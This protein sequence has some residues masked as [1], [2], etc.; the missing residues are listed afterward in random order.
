MTALIS[1]DGE[2]W[3]VDGT[4][5]TFR[6]VI[7]RLVSGEPPLLRFRM[8]T[9]GDEGFLLQ[10]SCFFEGD[11]TPYVVQRRDGDPDALARDIIEMYETWHAKRDD[12]AGLTLSQKLDKWKS[13]ISDI[14]GLPWPPPVRFIPL[15]NLM[16]D[17]PEWGQ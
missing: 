7:E 14:D 12:E 5:I 11:R 8:R 13:A 15:P 6:S 9:G 4:P 1:T 3:D 2:H 10:A 16:S 17:I